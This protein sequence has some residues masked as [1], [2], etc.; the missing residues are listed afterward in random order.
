MA[1]GDNLTHEMRVRGGKNSH[2]GKSRGRKG[3][4]S[5]RRGR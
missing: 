3:G 2:R 4:Q 1:R 5:M